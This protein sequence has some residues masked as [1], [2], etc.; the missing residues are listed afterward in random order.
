[1]RSRSTDLGRLNERGSV[2]AELALALPAVVL[3]LVALLDV[4]QALV[5]RIECVD[6]VRAGA[7]AAARAEPDT[8][9]QAVVRRLLPLT[10][11]VVLHDGDTVRVEAAG[12][13]RLHGPVGAITMRCAATAVAEAP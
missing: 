1:V 13:V 11:A 8:Q 2:T 3:V 6:A 10:V 7:R 9:V 4:G 12:V 5:A